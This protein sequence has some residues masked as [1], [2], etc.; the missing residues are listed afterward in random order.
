MLVQGEDNWLDIVAKK[1]EK[2][3]YLF[4]YCPRKKQFDEIREV[5]KE[6]VEEKYVTKEFAKHMLPEQIWFNLLVT[7]ST[8][9]NW[10]NA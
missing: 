4:K 5:L 8:Q 6:G 7:K 2:K 3:D 9:T 10:Q 1:R